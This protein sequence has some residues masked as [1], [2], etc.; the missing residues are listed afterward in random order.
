MPEIKDEKRKRK[1]NKKII[2][3]VSR[4]ILIFVVLAIFLNDAIVFGGSVKLFLE[5]KS[6]T[7]RRDLL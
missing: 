1:K 6:D 3:Q 4:T 2:F 5:A 7:I